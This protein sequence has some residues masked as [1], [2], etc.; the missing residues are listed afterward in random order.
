MTPQPPRTIYLRPPVCNLPA[1]PS[2]LGPSGARPEHDAAG[3][4][5]GSVIA[6]L[7]WLIR[8]YQVSDEERTW[9]EAAKACMAA[10][11]P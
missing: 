6:S 4:E 1:E 2:K 9:R 7:G 3:K 11:E 8:V 10:A 5:T